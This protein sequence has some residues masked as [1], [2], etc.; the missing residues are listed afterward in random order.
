MSDVIA[1]LSS[2]AGGAVG[3][4]R[5]SGTDALAVAGQVFHPASGLA[6]ADCPPRKLVL[7]D[8]V[9]GGK[10]ID[11]PLAAAFPG[12]KTFTGEPMAEIHCHGSAAVLETALLALFRAGARQARPGEFTRRAFLNGKMDLFAAEAVADLV[13]ARTPAAAANAVRQMG[14]KMSGELAALRA[15]LVGLC[16]HFLAVIDYPDEEIEDLPLEEIRAT[17]ARTDDRLHELLATFERGRM[18]T[19]GVPCALIGRPN[20]GK[21]TLLNAMLGRERAIVTEIAG[22]TR[23]TI[24]E[25]VRAGDLLLRLSDTAGLRETADPVEQI[26][27]A[28]AKEAAAVAAAG[29][30]VL[31]LFDGSRPLADEDEQV[32]AACADAPRKLALV[33]KCDLPPACDLSVLRG[34]FDRVLP[35]SARSGEGMDGLYAALN[36]LLLG[37]ALPE[38]GGLITNVRQAGALT[39]AAAC[40]GRARAALALGV[41]PDAVLADLEGA[42]AALGELDGSTVRDDIIDHI[43]ANFCVGK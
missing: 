25:T 17:V 40:T 28:R 31:A 22:T 24:E 37:E 38:D 41:T 36:D 43:F 2:P 33:T 18:L 32:L 30:V 14:G 12:D 19:E 4:I 16:G 29:G 11:R 20:A 15:G 21:S 6:L 13:A 35:V 10:V 27:V 1:A 34:H 8:L 9:A 3:V 7:G 23:D 42:I 39:E 5:I 26:G